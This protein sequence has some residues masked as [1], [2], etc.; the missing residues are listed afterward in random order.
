MPQECMLY[1]RKINSSFPTYNCSISHQSWNICSYKTKLKLFLNFVYLR[2]SQ[3]D[4]LL[5]L[6]PNS[7]SLSASS[8]TVAADGCARS[9]PRSGN[10]EGE[11]EGT[12]HNEAFSD[13]DSDW[14]AACGNKKNSVG[15]CNL[16]ET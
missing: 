4:N 8:E 13:S 15:M 7:S 1:S 11:E 6:Y 5:Q 3:R 9:L 10:T 14:L 12:S 2:A 16:T